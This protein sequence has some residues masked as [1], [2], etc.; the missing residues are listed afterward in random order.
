MSICRKLASEIHCA[1]EKILCKNCV[2]LFVSMKRW[3]HCWVNIRKQWYTVLRR[4]RGEGERERGKGRDVSWN[5]R[6]ECLLKCYQQICLGC[7]VS[8]NL[9][10]LLYTFLYCFHFCNKILFWLGK[11][12]YT[13]NTMR[14]TKEWKKYPHINHSCLWSLREETKGSFLPFLHFPICLLPNTITFKM[15]K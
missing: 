11:T 1:Y 14:R 13:K 4:E 10:F 2:S 15:R 12:K 6:K 7:G 8:S 5:E 9:Y 3:P